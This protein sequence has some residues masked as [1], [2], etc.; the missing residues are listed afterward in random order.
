[1]S[2]ILMDGCAL[3]I[4]RCNFQCVAA[5]LNGLFQQG[6]G[7]NYVLLLI[8]VIII[9]FSSQ[10]EGYLLGLGEFNLHIIICVPTIPSILTILII[11]GILK[12]PGALWGSP[13]S[14]CANHYSSHDYFSCLIYS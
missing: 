10:S 1:M 13:D 11:P 3:G 14:F 6:A 4:F 5:I 8:T 7:S 12:W 9:K 2:Q